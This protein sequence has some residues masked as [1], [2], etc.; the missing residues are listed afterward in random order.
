MEEVTAEIQS[1]IGHAQQIYNEINA[2]MQDLFE[3]PF[4]TTFLEHSDAFG[5]PVSFLSAN[6]KRLMI[7]GGVGFALALMFWFIHAL[8]QDIEATKRKLAEKEA[9]RR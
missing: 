1:A 3:S 8:R 2:H 6:G 7:G 9:L 5:K 4:F